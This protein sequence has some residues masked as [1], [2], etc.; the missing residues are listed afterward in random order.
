MLRTYALGPEKVKAGSGRAGR[1][2]EDPAA[3]GGGGGAGDCGQDAGEGGRLIL[4]RS[5]SRRSGRGSGSR[6]LGRLDCPECF[7]LGAGDE[8]EVV[9]L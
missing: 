3:A 4:W 2:I 5:G 1:L 8:G 6:R 7:G 9:A